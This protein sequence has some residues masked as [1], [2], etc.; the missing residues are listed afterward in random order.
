V[1]LWQLFL[2]PACPGWV[3]EYRFARDLSQE[4]TRQIAAGFYVKQGSYYHFSTIFLTTGHDP[5]VKHFFQSM[6]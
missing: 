2:V 5:L 1:S 4:E 6:M 3:L